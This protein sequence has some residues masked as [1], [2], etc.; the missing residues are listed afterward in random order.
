MLRLVG[1]LRLQT[2][3]SLRLRA[4]QSKPVC[5]SLHSVSEGR[6]KALG[7]AARHCFQHNGQTVYEWEQE[8]RWGML[9]DRGPNSSWRRPSYDETPP[10]ANS[11]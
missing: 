3:N 1:V 9:A 8:Y 2:R 5:C 4:A 10:S 7:M 11:A 6:C